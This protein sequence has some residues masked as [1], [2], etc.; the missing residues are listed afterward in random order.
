LEVKTSS[1]YWTQQSPTPSTWQ[2]EGIFG[3][4]CPDW[5]YYFSGGAPLT[6]SWWDPAVFH[7][8]Y[9]NVNNLGYDPLSMSEP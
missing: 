8:P 3:L 6:I 2:A 1:L 5:A 4:G 9:I 7:E